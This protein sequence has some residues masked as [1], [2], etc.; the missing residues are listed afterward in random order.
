MPV[1]RKVLSSQHTYLL[2]V[3]Q[4]TIAQ[5]NLGRIIVDL[6]GRYITPP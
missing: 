3:A 6:S 2:P 1:F 4:Y 5:K